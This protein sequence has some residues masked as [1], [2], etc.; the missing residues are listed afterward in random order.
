[1]LLPFDHFSSSSD[2]C[3][4]RY[5]L[6]CSTQLYTLSLHDAL[7]IW[8]C[9]FSAHDTD[10]WGMA[11]VSGIQ[12]RCVIWY[13]HPQALERSALA[14]AGWRSAEHTSELQ[15]RE[16]LVCRPLLEKTKA[17]AISITAVLP[18]ST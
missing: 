12:A 4:H 14:A 13:G 7:P 15:S 11:A 18:A 10:R 8:P 3:Q 9:W 17:L 5:T 2:A 1:A 16:K 6:F